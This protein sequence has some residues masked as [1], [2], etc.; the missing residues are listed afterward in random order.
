MIFV[1]KKIMLLNLR[2]SISGF[3]SS[4]FENTVNG[5]ALVSTNKLISIRSDKQ[6]QFD[7]I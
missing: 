3:L 1:T 7:S 6:K 4:V 2:K 5:Y